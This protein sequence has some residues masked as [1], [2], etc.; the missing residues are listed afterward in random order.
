MHSPFWHL[1][2][3]ATRWR[4]CISLWTLAP[5]ALSARADPHPRSVISFLRLQCLSFFFLRIYKTEI[6]FTLCVLV[7]VCV[8]D[9]QGQLVSPVL[10][11]MP[12]SSSITATDFVFIMKMPHFMEV[13]LSLSRSLSLS[14]FLCLCHKLTFARQCWQCDCGKCIHMSHT[15]VLNVFVQCSLDM[16]ASAISVQGCVRVIF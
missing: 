8:C 4:C 11:A 3:N 12:S 1:Y 6:F 15:H 9:G 14:F 5:S 10:T 13:C 7:C 2:R 16:V